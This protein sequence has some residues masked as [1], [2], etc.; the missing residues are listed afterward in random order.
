MLLQACPHYPCRPSET[1]CVGN[2]SCLTSPS[3]SVLTGT[4]RRG[5]VRQRKVVS[6]PSTAAAE[7]A[8]K[9]KKGGEGEAEMR[10]SEESWMEGA[11]LRSLSLMKWQPCNWTHH[12][13]H[14]PTHTHTHPDSFT[15]GDTHF[16][17]SVM[18]SVN[19][20]L[21]F[22]FS[23]G[24]GDGAWAQREREDTWTWEK[25]LRSGTRFFRIPLTI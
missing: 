13:H 17:C 15:A 6:S 23:S 9:R 22:S 4:C 18:L 8:S 19:D 3:S 12:P 14:A 5:E 24:L 11:W 10:S 21:F 25:D 7:R 1:H 2:V 20:R 16:N